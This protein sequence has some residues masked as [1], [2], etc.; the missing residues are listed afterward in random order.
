MPPLLPAPWRTWAFVGAGYTYVYDKSFE[1]FPPMAAPA[2][3]Q[4]TSGGVIDFPFGVALGYRVKAP[5]TLFVEAGGRVG[6]AFL[7]EG[8]PEVSSG[9]FAFS[10]A[11]P[12]HDSFAIS[13]A[14][15]LSFDP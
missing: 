12:G 15:G 5:W 7:G 1:A 11:H 4:G 2:T 9:D 13:L 6:A 10:P 8:G 14:V 3:V